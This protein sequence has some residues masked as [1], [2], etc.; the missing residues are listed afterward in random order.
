MTVEICKKLIQQKKYKKAVN[1]L[2]ELLKKKPN[3]FKA[4]FHVGRI[5]YDLNILDK[6]VF[7]LTLCLGY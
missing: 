1:I 7:F 3:D 4:N 6:S 2:S 5:Y